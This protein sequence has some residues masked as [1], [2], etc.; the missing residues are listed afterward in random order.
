MNAQINNV[1]K[2]KE[3]FDIPFIP[4][5]YLMYTMFTLQ[6]PYAKMWASA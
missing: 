2:E 6:D 1:K 4:M 5:W 3:R